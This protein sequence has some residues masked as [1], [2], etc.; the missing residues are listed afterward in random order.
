MSNGPFKPE[1]DFEKDPEYARII[2]KLRAVEDEKLSKDFDENLF[3]K[4]ETVRP[5]K[6]WL[7]WLNEKISTMILGLRMSRIRLG[8]SVAIAVLVVGVVSYLVL[9]PGA[10]KTPYWEQVFRDL[11]RPHAYSFTNEKGIPKE[12]EEPERKT[13]LKGKVNDLSTLRYLQQIDT[14]KLFQEK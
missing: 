7:F 3:K 10:K 1:T 11:S 12:L 13:G 6:P 2:E 5:R 14:A 4:L 9:Q 8:A